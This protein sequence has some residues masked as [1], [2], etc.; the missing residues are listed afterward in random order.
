MKAK[1]YISLLLMIAVLL[2]FPVNAYAT[3]DKKVVNSAE[4]LVLS[5]GTIYTNVLD[6]CRIVITV[7]V[8][9]LQAEINYSFSSEP[10][11]VFQ[12]VVN[13]NEIITPDGTVNW[14]DVNYL[15]RN[16]YS[17][18]KQIDI[19]FEHVRYEE[20][21]DITNTRGGVRISFEA[22]LE[23]LHGAEYEG[24]KMYESVRLGERIK[25]YQRQDYRIEEIGA[26]S[27]TSTAAFLT[28]GAFISGHL[29]YDA[30]EETVSTIASVL[31]VA[32][33]VTTIIASSGSIDEYSCVVL[34]RRYATI[35]D[36]VYIYNIT[37]DIYSY[38]GYDDGDIHSDNPSE[39]V[40]SSLDHYYSHSSAYFSN[41]SAQAADAYD[42]FTRIGQQP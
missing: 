17:S 26:F 32:D 16:Q 36:S 20:P 4:T 21:I 34:V 23:V 41:Y 30:T 28:L 13:K 38:T 3:A 12:I 7:P 42:L 18:A 29:G 9:S 33:S 39:V 40:I 35:N 14:S 25:I 5:D 2:S 15:C 1:R 6:N 11:R 37:D 10:G 27:W 24:L 22:A 8:N 19:V 31:G